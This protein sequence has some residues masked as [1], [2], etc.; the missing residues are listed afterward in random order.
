V[1]HLYD[2]YRKARRP[3]QRAIKEAKRRAWDELLTT[4][5]SDPWGRPYRLVLNKLRPWAPPTTV[6]M[7]PQFLEEV[8]GAL[9]PGAVNEEEGRTN[10]ERELRL[11]EEE[12]RDT[13]GNWS[14]ESAITED[15]LAGA[16]EKI[17]ARKAP[18]PDGVP[19]RVWQEVAGVLA[20]RLRTL[21]DRCLS[22]GEFPVLWK[23]GRMVLL[24]KPGRSPDSSFAF[25]PV[26]LLN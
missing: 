24:L 21:F 11:P 3:L 13:A 5:D 18:S 9:F 22:R 17:G 8:V 6:N 23:E 10:E 20:P 25:R 2:A 12:P 7:D 14:P 26:C 16:V 19:A 4:L 15:E 1:A